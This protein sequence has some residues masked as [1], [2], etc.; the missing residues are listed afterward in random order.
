[1]TE[2]ADHEWPSQKISITLSQAPK[3]SFLGGVMQTQILTSDRGLLGNFARR[4]GAVLAMTGLLMLSACDSAGSRVTQNN[5]PEP[6]GKDGV[7]PTLTSVSIRESTKSAKPAGTVEPGKAVRVDLTASESLMTPLVTINGVEAEVIGK[8]T[9]WFAIRGLTADDALGEVTFT[10][11]Y[12]DISGELG[13]PVSATTDGSALVYCDEDCP[14]PVSLAGDWRLDVVGGA[15]VGPAAGDI[16]WWSTDIAGVVEIRACWFDDIFRLGADGSFQ[17]IQGDETWLEDWQAGSE[18]CGAPL[19]PHDGSTA[20]TWVYDEGAGTITIGGA[21]AHLGLPRTVN[22]G[23][24]PSVAVPDSVTYDVL[25]FDLGAMTVTIDVGG[26]NWWT[27]KLAR[28]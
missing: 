23:E 13:V 2:A 8:A 3:D 24:I 9:G 21:G 26:G 28:E 22:G 25:S 10:I 7:A 5:L 4:F 16:S 14:E 17:N 19:A 18:Q 11:V 15:G 6:S 1:M 12:Q 27:Y 20:G